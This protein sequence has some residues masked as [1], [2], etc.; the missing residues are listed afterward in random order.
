MSTIR[1]WW[2]SDHENAKDF[3]YNYLH[4]Y[5]LT[6]MDCTPDIVMAIIEDHLA[7]P[8]MLAIFPVQDLIGTEASLRRPDANAEQINEPSN[9]KHYWKFRFHINMEDLIHADQL[10]SKLRSMVNRHGR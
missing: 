10:N 5:G 1:G 9:P 4:W 2:Q 8:S 3:Y 7:S 6:P